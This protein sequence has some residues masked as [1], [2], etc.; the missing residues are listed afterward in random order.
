MSTNNL[1]DDIKNEPNV[2]NVTNSKP[3]DA[4]EIEFDWYTT[5]AKLWDEEDLTCPPHSHKFME[6][7]SYQ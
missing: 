7:R 6:C 1:P 2:T 3:G 4:P 5:L